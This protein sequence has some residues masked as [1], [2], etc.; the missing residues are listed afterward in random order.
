VL[1]ADCKVWANP[2]SNSL[3]PMAQPASSPTVAS[4]ATG[5]AV[6]PMATMADVAAT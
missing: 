3:W 5:P 1:R 4:A 6:R 2:M